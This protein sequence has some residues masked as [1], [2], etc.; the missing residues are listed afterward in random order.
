MRLLAASALSLLTALSTPAIASEQFR[1]HVPSVLFGVPGDDGGDEGDGGGPPDNGTSSPVEVFA[2]DDLAR[3]DDA[4]VIDVHLS[5]ALAS[6]VVTLDGPA[7]LAWNR[8]ANDSG[9]ITWAAAQEGAHPI[10]IMVATAGGEP[11]ASKSITL[12]VRGSL[13]ASVPQ[14]SFQ[15]N[16]GESLTITPTAQNLMGTSSEV[17]WSSNPQSLPSWLSFNGSTGEI[18]VDT[19][20]ER[21]LSGIVL[22]AVDQID[23]K[24]APTQAFSVTVQDSCA[25]WMPRALTGLEGNPWTTMAYGNGMFAAVSAGGGTNRVMTSPDG[26]AWTGRTAEDSQWQGITYGNGRFVAVANGGTKRI[27]TSADGI[28]WTAQTS[29]EV[30]GWTG[31]TYGN[32]QFV[33]V[34]ESGTNRVM[35]SPDGL[36]WTVRSAPAGAWTSVA[37]GNGRYA[38]VGYSGSN[39]VITSEDGLTWTARSAP[40]STWTSVAYG[41]GVFAAVGSLGAT[42]SSPDGLVWTA[43][44]NGSNSWNRVAY[45]GGKFV[46][47]ANNGTHRIATSPNGQTWTARA[48]PDQNDWRGLAYGNG[49]FAAVASSGSGTMNRLMTSTC[50]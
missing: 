43:R 39:R 16:L 27:M 5:G 22:T 14:A 2:A 34:A 44:T 26:I 17:L 6:D 24:S 21:T 40:S 8:S 1:M 10:T 18:T 20:S 9:T 7:G 48:V 30:S 23:F 4:I 45:G 33:A 49:I 25:V 31:V 35:T 38:A 46:A 50:N 13:T 11:K 19:A 15:V 32:G 36:T 29:P 41:G 3:Q 42:M 47:L 12:T 37:Y 28:T